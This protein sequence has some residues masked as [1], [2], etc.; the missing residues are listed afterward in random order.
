MK[1]VSIFI[2]TYNRAP[3]LAET[4]E[5]MTRVD[6]GGF[7]VEW[8]IINNN[9]SDDT[10]AVVESFKERLPI[11]LVHE[12]AAGKN[13]ALNRALETCRIP[14]IAV[15]T[16]DDVSP[17]VGWIQEIVGSCDR[18]PD[19]DVFGGIIRPRWPDGKKPA[20]ITQPWLLSIGFAW[21]D[22][23]KEEKP[24]PKATYPFGPNFWVRGELFRKGI[25]YRES[26]GPVG[27]N[28]IMGSETSFLKD[29]DDLGHGMVYCP[30]A[31]LEHRIKET[32]YDMAVL[33]RR[34]TSYGRGRARI[35]GVNYRNMMT[36]H[37][38]KWWLRQRA[39]LL[40]ARLRLGIL[41]LIPFSKPR[42]ERLLWQNSTIGWIEESFRIAQETGK[43]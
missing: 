37:P 15:F 27:D 24:Y 23:G 31:G 41:R 30:H 10:D 42:R 38:R 20:W 22:H 14:D 43:S 36:E 6:R 33:M 1:S 19:H 13:R 35:H 9:C 2:A 16:D 11:R 18:W 32:D 26:I 5:A 39:K 40:V 7:D 12:K 28:R 25:R 17:D 3:M 8:V 29:L 21:H 4:L 34:M